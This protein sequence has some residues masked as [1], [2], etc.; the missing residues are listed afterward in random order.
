MGAVAIGVV[1]T[2]LAGND[3]HTIVIVNIAVL[4]IIYSVVGNFTGIDPNIIGKILVVIV[5]AGINYSNDRAGAAAAILLQLRGILKSAFLQVPLLLDL[6][7]IAVSANTG[8][9]VNT[10]RLQRHLN[11][12]VIL[13][14]QN[15]IQLAHCSQCLHSICAFNQHCLVPGIALQRKQKLQRTNADGFQAIGER[16][17]LQLDQDGLTREYHRAIFDEFGICLVER[18]IHCAILI[19]DIGAF[20]CVICGLILIAGVIDQFVN[21]N[22]QISIRKFRRILSANQ[23]DEQFLF[24]PRRVRIAAGLQI[25]LRRQHFLISAFGREAA[26][27]HAKNHGNYQQHRYRTLY[28]PHCSTS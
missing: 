11:L 25:V 8:I 13:S 1:T 18:H 26:S 23:I 9:I 15:F 3:I 14:K 28:F 2:A 4:I 12:I 5:H 20:A 19:I 22:I 27:R 10:I 7:A 6:I 24:L 16:S 17:V 21:Q